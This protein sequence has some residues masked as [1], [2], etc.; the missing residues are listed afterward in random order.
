M[1]SRGERTKERRFG[2]DRWLLGLLVALSLAG[3]AWAQGQPATDGSRCVVS[4]AF[5]RADSTRSAGARKYLDQLVASRRGLHLVYRD[6]DKN[7]LANKRL[8]DIAK[9]FKVDEPAVPTIYLCRQMITGFQD[10]ATTG[11][12]IEDLLTIEAFVREG[13]PKCA[14]AKAHLMGMQSRYPGFKVVFR[15]I[16]NDAAGRARWEEVSRQ[17]G[18]VTPGIPTFHAC[19][20]VIVGWDGEQ[21]TGAQWEHILQGATFPCPAAKAAAHN[22]DRRRSGVRRTLLRTSQPAVTPR[23]AG[24][25][26]EPPAPAASEELPAAKAAANSNEPPAPLAGDA[27]L[28]LAGDA[29]P[30]AAG[31]DLELVG[32]PAE[33]SGSS[34][35]SAGA[36]NSD[37][38]SGVTLPVFG[39]LELRSV[40]LPALTFAVG[41]VDGFNPCAMWVLLFLLSVLVNLKDRWKILAVAGTFVLVSGL[42]YFA[43]MAAW[44]NVF[45]LVGYLRPVQIGLGVIG[46]VVGLVHVKDFFAFKKGVTFSIPESAKTGIYDRVRRI[47]SAENLFAAITGAVVLAVLVNVVELLCTAGLPALYTQILAQQQ[48]P[49]WQYYAYLGLYNLAYMFDDSIMVGMVVFT[50]NRRRLQEN[51]G[52]WLKFV[53]GATMLAMG[54]VMLVKPQWLV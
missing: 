20:K 3:D 49:T 12:Q 1:L 42:A 46:L 30:P 18:V 15:E 50:L 26:D 48:L 36:S 31:E 35:S 51:E 4:E 54:L 41:I 27:P 34:V 9:F 24:A 21:A 2:K 16:I 14:S 7:E 17:H 25:K 8:H 53:S 32:P 38:P 39:R 10:A 19:G 45:K 13:C 44:L 6:V 23:R 37:A 43:F 29:P 28:P 40:G 11:R 22:N 33:A 5:V 52:R 47:V